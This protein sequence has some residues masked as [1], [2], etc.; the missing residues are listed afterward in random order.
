MLED[1]DCVTIAAVDGV[2][3]GGGLELTLC[4]DFVLATPNSRWG[5]PEIDMGITPGWGG[6]HADAALCRSPQSARRST[7]WPTS[8]ADEKPKTS[9]SSIGSSRAPDLE[10][11][12]QA[13]TAHMLAKNRYAIRRTKFVLNKAA[14]GHLA[15]ATAFEVPL[16]PAGGHRREPGRHPELRGQDDGLEGHP[17]PRREGSGGVEYVFESVEQVQQITEDWLVEY[18]EQRPH[19]SL[20]RVPPLTYLPREINAGESSFKLSP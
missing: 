3:M 14:E 6:W 10:G 11:E 18:N 8:S 20:G 17:V 15:Q 1:L 4:C 19:D 12:V 5:M 13:L 9:G 7:C 2:C 16:D